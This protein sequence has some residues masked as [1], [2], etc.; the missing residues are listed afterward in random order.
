MRVRRDERV[1]L[2]GHGVV[3]ARFEL[4]GHPGLD[5]RQARLVESRRIGGGERLV[6]DVRERRA[7]PEAERLREVGAGDE[8]LEADGVELAGLDA[9]QVAR[10]ARDDPVGTE[11]LAQGVDVH[12]ERAANARGRLVAPHRVDQPV[13]RDRFVA[14]Q[15]EER[16]NRSRA[17]SAERQRL[18]AVP[19]HL[20]RPEHPELHDPPKPPLSPT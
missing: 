19:E 20:Q 1:E 9:N 5:R 17:L 8:L 6:C 10:R 14:M 7:A 16:E 4:G 2:S 11:R 3:C 15:Q 12:L 13:G 18:A